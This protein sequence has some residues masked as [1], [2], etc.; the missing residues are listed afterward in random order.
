MRPA[1]EKEAAMLNEYMCFATVPAT[2]LARARSWYAEKLGLEPTEETAEGLRYDMGKGTGFLLYP[3]QFAGTNQATAMGW[4]VVDFDAEAAELRKRGVTFEEYDFE[5]VK[6]V[7]GV[8]TMPDGSR[9]CWFKDS[10][11]N[12]LSVADM[13]V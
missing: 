10:E 7:D 13:P 12:I 8:M 5:E 11:G 6:T 1:R 2:D 9:G 4:A 3:S